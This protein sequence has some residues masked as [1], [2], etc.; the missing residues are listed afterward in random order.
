MNRLK[1]TL[2]YLSGPMDEVPDLGRD[3]RLEIQEFLWSLGVG[4][5]NPCDKPTELGKEDEDLQRLTLLL[6]ADAEDFEAQGKI[7][8]ADACYEQIEEL[9]NPIVSVDFAMVDR[10]GFIIL[11]VDKDY[12]MCGSYSEET[13]AVLQKKPVIICCKQG[14]WCIPNFLFKRK[15]RHKTMFSNWKQ[16]REYLFSVAHDE[17]VDD[18]G[19]WK[20]FDYEKVYGKNSESI[21]S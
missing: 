4:V 15:G 18:L 20:F 12:H 6:R 1:G 11:Y 13:L 9:M 21:Y 17:E 10:A 7:E 14:K 19:V 5:L 3:W 16:V 8:M 2:A